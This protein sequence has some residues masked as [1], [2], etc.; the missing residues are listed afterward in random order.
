MLDQSLQ[1]SWR[2]NFLGL[3]FT[4]SAYLIRN[5]YGPSMAVPCSRDGYSARGDADNVETQG[6][7]S[8]D[9]D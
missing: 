1:K 5:W 3:P 4:P 8:G 7:G 2:S 6:G 9:F